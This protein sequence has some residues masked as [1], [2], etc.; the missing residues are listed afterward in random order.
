[1]KCELCSQKCLKNL[2]KYGLSKFIKA[3]ISLATEIGTFDD[4]CPL[5]CLI[6]YLL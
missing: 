2:V 1:M 4:K 6:A 5:K 3:L